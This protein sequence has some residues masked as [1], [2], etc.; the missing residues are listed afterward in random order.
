MTLVH[1]IQWK[2]I[3]WYHQYHRVCLIFTRTT[4]C[5]SEYDDL[6]QI[7]FVYNYILN[8]LAATRKRAFNLVGQ[9]YDSINI[10][11]L[12]CFVGMSSSDTAQGMLNGNHA[13]QFLVF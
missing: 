9:A 5:H 13:L 4:S 11:D 8:I 2:K 3:S 10:D 12:A 1:L 7:Y 6:N